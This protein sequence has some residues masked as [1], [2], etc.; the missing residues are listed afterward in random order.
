MKVLVMPGHDFGPTYQD[1]AEQGVCRLWELGA[2]RWAVQAVMPSARAPAWYLNFTAIGYQRIAR[3]AALTDRRYRLIESVGGEGS[4]ECIVTDYELEPLSSYPFVAR[5]AAIR[6]V[7][8]ALSPRPVSHYGLGTERYS[9]ADIGRLVESCGF[10]AM[11]MS[12]YP[13]SHR[14]NQPPDLTM[15]LLLCKGA[16]I[17]PLPYVYG[18][19]ERGEYASSHLPDLLKWCADNGATRCIAWCT[20]ADPASVESVARVIDAAGGVE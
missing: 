4:V 20:L 6:R 5:A 13:K 3:I 18:L 14:A 17:E 7:C 16:K 19:N 10:S 9:V 2:R 15:D 8:E 11:A 1:L 12:A